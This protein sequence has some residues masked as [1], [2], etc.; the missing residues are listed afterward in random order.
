[1]LD[2]D[3]T[4]RIKIIPVT[5]LMGM[6]A[7]IP[8]TAKEISLS[9]VSEETQTQ[10]QEEK[11]NADF[12]VCKVNGISLTN[13]QFCEMYS[14]Y[15][16]VF[17]MQGYD[18]SSEQ[19]ETYISNHSYTAVIENELLS[20][21]MQEDGYTDYAALEDD[22]MNGYQCTENEIKEYYNEAVAQD[23]KNYKDNIALYEQVLYE[24]NTDIWYIPEGYRN[25]LEI[26][27]N[28]DDEELKDKM[29]AIKDAAANGRNFSE[30]V[31]EY[32]I[33]EETK[34]EEILENGLKMNQE[35]TVWNEDVLNA[36]FSEDMDAYGEISE[37]IEIDGKVYLFCYM[38][39]VPSGPVELTDNLKQHIREILWNNT[40]N[41]R[42]Q[43]YIKQKSS[44]AVILTL[45]DP[46]YSML[47]KE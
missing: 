19:L 28:G 45:A 15:M 7:A 21:G 36:V 25:V 20:Q 47:I 22:L 8:A 38:G 17:A 3:K 13:Q 43:D 27:L 40:V 41:E 10:T 24:T 12:T 39:D 14:Y 30:L 46:D 33:E 18:T 31:K 4:I 1:M 26:V 42:V 35:S 16:E 44:K 9:T 34:R 2:I 5:F 37:P 23:E 11:T 32:S 6:M 29:E